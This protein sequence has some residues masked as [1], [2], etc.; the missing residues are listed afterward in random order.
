V[1]LTAQQIADLATPPVSVTSV[2]GKVGTVSLV[3]ADVGA[4]PTGTASS[5]ISSH[6]GDAGAHGGVEGLLVA[7]VGS[8]GAAHADA[9]ASVA[10]FMSAADKTKL[11][12]ISI[13]QQVIIPS[14]MFYVDTAGDYKTLPEPTTSIT[15]ITATALS[16]SAVEIM[17]TLIG[18]FTR[19]F[20]AGS[21]VNP[22]DL[23]LG[24]GFIAFEVPEAAYIGVD[25]ITPLGIFINDDTSL[26]YD[27]TLNGRLDIVTVDPVPVAAKCFIL[28]I[29]DS[30]ADIGKRKNLALFNSADSFNYLA[31]PSAITIKTVF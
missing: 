19:S 25:G 7:H 13:T 21:Y 27:I 11:D 22:V 24:V 14:R 28:G 5:A 15:G 4:D 18:R 12:G 1:R 3:A 10:G 2:N 26:V 20:V 30:G 23:N 9:T 31:A 16:F 29:Q 8:S 6:N 17:R